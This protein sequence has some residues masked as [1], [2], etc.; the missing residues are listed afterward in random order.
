MYWQPRSVLNGFPLNSDHGSVYTSKDYARLCA[1]LE[2][3]QSMG[4]VG[5]SA[6]NALAESFN[7]TLKREVLQD[8]VYWADEATCRREVFGWL[9]RYNTTRR[10]SWCPVPD[11]NRLRNHP[12]RYAPVS[13]MKPTPCPKTGGK[14]R[15][16]GRNPPINVIKKPP[17]SVRLRS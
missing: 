9:V 8:A 2:V 10:H 11:P 13:G 5:T 12:R 6:D 14:A 7:A 15:Q 4:A 1:Q 16:L 3:T 17:S